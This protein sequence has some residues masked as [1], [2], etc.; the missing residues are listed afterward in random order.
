MPLSVTP[1]LVFLDKLD[2][3]RRP[4]LYTYY[5]N[6]EHASGHALP[7]RYPTPPHGP[8]ARPFNRLAAERPGRL[9]GLRRTKNTPLARG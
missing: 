5:Y 2:N 7:T 6:E 9:A 8:P 4:F 3:R 1:K